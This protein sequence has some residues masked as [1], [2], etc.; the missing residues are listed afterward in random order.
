MAAKILMVG[1]IMM[2]LILQMPRVPHPSESILGTTYSNAG[3]GKGSNS[4]VAAAKAGAEVSVCG[5]LGQD[6]NGEA[7][8]GM[9]T[10]IGIDVSN[11]VLKEGANTG[12][13]VIMLEEDGMNRI[14]IYTGTNNDTTPQSV[15]AA[16]KG[17]EYD[18]L[19]M[20]LEIP[21]ETNVHA[22]ELAKERGMIT[23]LD[24][25]PA[26]DYPLEKFKNITILSPNETETEALV[27]ILPTDDESCIAASKILQERSEC[28]YVVL[29]MGD[30]GS[31]IYGEGISQMIPTFKVKSVDPTAAGDCFTGVLVKQYAETGD[32]IA[33]ARYASA[34][35]AISV[36][37]LGAQPSLPTKEAIDAFLAERRQS[38]GWQI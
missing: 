3:G 34:A 5:T 14:A 20:Q 30:K 21:L 9:L 12:M 18:A 11:L 16:F 15:D 17:K 25:G 37:H 7:L 36:Q 27:G 28:K 1:S 6:A 29:K 24:A 4:A 33:S 13:A 8:V 10:D 26:Q 22:F 32:I 2:D 38:V 19:M 23:C 35:A 31:F